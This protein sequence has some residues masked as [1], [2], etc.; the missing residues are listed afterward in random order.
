MSKIIKLLIGLVVSVVLLVFALSVALTYF[1]KPTFIK[2][3]A[4]K[5]FNDN[6]DRT[7]DIAGDVHWSIFPTVGLTA[8]NITITN[9]KEFGKSNFAQAKNVK[10][11]LKLGSLL[12]GH[13][14]LR[15]LKMNQVTLN[16][17]KNKQGKA[18]WEFR[19]IGDQNK[20]DS[21]QGQTFHVNKIVLKN[22]NINFDNQQS[23]RKLTFSNVNLSTSHIH[24]N[25]PFRIS[26]DANVKSTN[27]AINSYIELNGKAT[28]DDKNQ[29]L[30]VK[31]FEFSSTHK[32]D[33]M[34]TFSIHTTGFID[35]KGET[36]DL[37]PIEFEYAKTLTG[38]GKLKGDQIMSNPHFSGTLTTNTFN[39][40]NLLNNVGYPIVMKD[41]NT[42][43]K[44]M[45]AGDIQAS[46]DHIAM[47]NLKAQI[48]DTALSGKLS[49]TI[50]NNT[51]NMDLSGNHLNLNHFST[52]S[53]NQ[54]HKKS[55]EPLNLALAGQLRFKRVFIST[56][57]LNNVNTKLIYKD[58]VLILSAF[59]CDLF[60]GKTRGSVTLNTRNKLLKYKINQNMSSINMGK[61]LG[62][63]INSRPLTGTA[64]IAINI[65]GIGTNGN[66]IKRN[67][68]G[69]I[70]IDVVNGIAQGVDVDHQFS[71][72]FAFLTKTSV[73]KGN[74]KQTPFQ[75]A[76]AKFVISKGQLNNPSINMTLPKYDI[77][78]SGSINMLNQGINY[79]VGIKP[80]NA[81]M[82]VTPVSRTN[83]ANFYI[84]LHIGGT[85]SNPKPT[86]DLPGI[87]QITLKEAAK[88]I[89]T[90]QIVK[91]LNGGIVRDVISEPVGKVLRKVLPFNQN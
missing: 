45:I 49:Y 27:P 56:I 52:I 14:A 72:V 3:E 80:L 7:I 12:T 60:D 43:K 71:R 26:G 73:K 22:S 4:T 76:S 83:L 13:I 57:N 20:K 23:N 38:R 50:A 1:I 61:M 24:F 77:K 11:D 28:Y 47:T 54:N 70:N 74:T 88:E 18:N 69:T 46:S 89:I 40:I 29:K 86:L 19:F 91:P 53:N 2:N 79:K 58:G 78:G 67:L 35:F 6:T 31:D 59:S 90:E 51:I 37:S 44:V 17:I 8:N 85:L 68:N 48:D 55:N 34:R 63:T 75:K 62:Q 84:P 81:V 30:T 42:L 39:L 87:A 32:N 65:S 16:L 82:V 25:R 33:P 9:P 41:K 5:W 21:S 10:V 66:N 64:Q 36:V 15:T